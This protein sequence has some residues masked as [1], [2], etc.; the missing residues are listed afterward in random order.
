MLRDSVA[1]VGLGRTEFSKN[2]GVSTLTLALRAI[3]GAVEDAGLSVKDIDGV[4]CHRIG[5]YGNA[6]PGPNL[7][8]VGSTLSTPQLEHAII[9]P[10]APMPSFSHLPTA[11][12]KAVVEFLSLLR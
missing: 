2:S 5:D 7:T 11:K 6:R 8:H 12:F 1:I 10:R 3:S 9:D 4:A